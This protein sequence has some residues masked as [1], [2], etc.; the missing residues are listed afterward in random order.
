MV[1]EKGNMA[2]IRR[3]AEEKRQATILR[4]E[5]AILSLKQAGMII[6]FNTVSKKAKVSTAWLYKNMK[7]AV[8]SLRIESRSAHQQTGSNSGK[9]GKSSS[10]DSQRAIL[11]ALRQ[12]V[13]KVEL[14]NQELRHQI[15]MLYGKMNNF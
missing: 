9:R 1:M 10:D 3:A 2:G 13:K 14:E 8:E 4:A 11:A 7:Q 12:R 5:S 15:E 6:N